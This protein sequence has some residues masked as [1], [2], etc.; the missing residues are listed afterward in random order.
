MGWGGWLTTQGHG[1]QRHSRVRQAT[2]DEPSVLYV[3]FQP[4][5]NEIFNL[6]LLCRK[7]PIT[8]PS[9]HR[10]CGNTPNMFQTE[11]LALM[12][13]LP[14][15]FSSTLE[16]PKAVCSLSTRSDEGGH[17]HTQPPLETV[18]GRSVVANHSHKL[19]SN[20]ASRPTHPLLQQGTRY[21]A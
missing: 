11:M 4:R 20:I 15:S 5:S 2:S 10:R 18:A 21:S 9:R 13:V 12:I 16:Q 7:L 17:A 1:L 14:L 6:L 3:S 19:V 8:I